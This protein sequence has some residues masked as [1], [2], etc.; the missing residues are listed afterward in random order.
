[1]VY[2][3]STDKEAAAAL[4]AME[5]STAIRPLL[6]RDKMGIH[7]LY[8]DPAGE[9]RSLETGSITGGSLR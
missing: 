1:M 5:R 9:L 6:G 4:Q 8:L 3:F 7:V 2:V